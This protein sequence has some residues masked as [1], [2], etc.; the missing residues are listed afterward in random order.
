MEVSD[1]YYLRSIEDP[2]KVIAFGHAEPGKYRI[3]KGY[4]EAQGELPK[5]FHL[6]TL[7]TLS[8]DLLETLTEALQQP[9]AA[10]L[11]ARIRGLKLVVADALREGAF[12][13]VTALIEDFPAPPKLKKFK[14]ALLSIVSVY[15]TE[16]ASNE[17]R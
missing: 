12:D 11:R 2:L 3:P 4:E 13:E 1:K 17:K 8:E 5:G 6:T 16:D 7:P 15:A 9:I 10:S 14:D